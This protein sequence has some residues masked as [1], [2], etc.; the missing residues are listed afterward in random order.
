M[1]DTAATPRTCRLRVVMNGRGLQL[2][3]QNDPKTNRN[4]AWG[5][6]IFR[7][8]R[9]GTHDASRCVASC[10]RLSLQIC[11]KSPGMGSPRSLFHRSIH[12]SSLLA[13][14]VGGGIS[15]ALNG[16]CFLLSSP[17]SRWLYHPESPHPASQLTP[18]LALGEEYHN[19]WII[20]EIIS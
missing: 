18:F 1:Y 10:A 20:S 13:A 14:R 5:P 17:S 4:S 15:I 7:R 6:E 11:R 8:A 19:L 2:L 16:Q 12:C 3:Y 9:N